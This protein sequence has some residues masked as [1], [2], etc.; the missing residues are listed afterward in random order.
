MAL[1]PLTEADEVRRAYETFA[2]VIIRDTQPFDRDLGF[3]GGSLSRVVHWNASLEFWAVLDPEVA[4]NRYWC[5]FG[6]ADPD[7]ATMLNI[8]CEINPPYAGINRRCAGVFVRGDDGQIYV[9]HS[10][11]VGG[12]R[13]GIGRSQFVTFSPGENWAAL[14]WADGSRTDAIIIGR[15]DGEHLPEQVA[16]F[17]RTVEGFKEAAVRG[18]LVQPLHDKE[19]AFT[20]EFSGMRENYEPTET[21]E[22]RCDHGLVVNALERALRSCGFQTANDKQRDLFIRAGDDSVLMLFEA[23]TDLHLGSI[24]CAVGQLMIHGATGAERPRRVLVVPGSPNER[25]VT[26][27][28]RLG[29]ETLTYTWDAG[30]PVFENLQSMLEG[31]PPPS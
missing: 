27:L 13:K 12:G 7:E 21:I 23:K 29:I 14:S 18:E 22:S 9:A 30:K 20:P 10:G 28:G 19:T 15:I 6:T 5:A 1:V 8:I 26:L 24:Y 4:Q 17:V 16:H 25:T 2:Q 31:F 11:K 3:Q